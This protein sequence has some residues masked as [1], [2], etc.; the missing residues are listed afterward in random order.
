MNIIFSQ[1]MT[2]VIDFKRCF[3][4]FPYQ[5]KVQLSNET[6]LMA[7]YELLPQVRFILSFI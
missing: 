4:N 3:L 6:D 7:K 5:G 2:P 1:I